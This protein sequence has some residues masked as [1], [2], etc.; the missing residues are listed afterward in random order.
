MTKLQTH[1]SDEGLFQIFLDTMKISDEKIFKDI[2]MG[3]F[4]L[5]GALKTIKQQDIVG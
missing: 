5:V 3:K 2:I 1:A 4:Q